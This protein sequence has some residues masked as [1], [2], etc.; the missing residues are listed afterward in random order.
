MNDRRLQVYQ[1]EHIRVT[2]DPAICRHSDKCHRALP[3]VFDTREREVA[4]HERQW[5]HPELDTA[6]A[7]MA[8]VAKCPT[9][10]LRAQ[11]VTS[12]LRIIRPDGES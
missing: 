7:I 4:S 3:A 11:L 5:V 8:A 10:A 2:Y 6:E 12:V 1:N 9:G